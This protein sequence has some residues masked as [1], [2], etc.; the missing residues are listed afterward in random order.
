[1]PRKTVEDRVDANRELLASM[2][3]RPMPRKTTKEATEKVRELFRA[4]MRPRPM[5]RKTAGYPLRH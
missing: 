2:R 3:P 1:M 4:S 5:P